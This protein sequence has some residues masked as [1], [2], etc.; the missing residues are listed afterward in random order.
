MT[1][2]L[3]VSVVLVAST[4]ASATFAQHGG[5]IVVGRSDATAP[6]I[7]LGE[8]DFASNVLLPEVSGVLQGWAD[9]EPGFDH[10]IVD[11]PPMYTLEAGA[12]IQFEV[13]R[14]TPA[15]R[16]IDNAFAVLDEPGESTI[17]GDEHLH[18]HVTWHINDQDPAF[19]PG[20]W[21][22][23]VT[24][25]LRD[26]GSTGYLPSDEVT[27]HFTTVACQSGDLDAN[28]TVNP[29]DITPFVNVLISGGTTEE[30]CAA[31]VDRNGTVN[32][33]D[34]GPFLELLSR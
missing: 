26:L 9:D 6:R 20:R 1:K 5:D 33:F 13:I 8:F 2:S 15:L 18:A 19:D 12:L 27:I 29:F 23:K 7:L 10:L 25:L 28:G 21:L 11:E 17:I 34:I 31:D 4:F 22:W 3:C 14:L 32:S 30:R 24:F 16:I